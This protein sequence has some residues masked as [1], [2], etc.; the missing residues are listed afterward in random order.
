MF[1]LAK[2]FAIDAIPLMLFGSVA[3]RTGYTLI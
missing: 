2:R 3:C 1:R